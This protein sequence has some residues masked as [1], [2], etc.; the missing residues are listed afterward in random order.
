MRYSDNQLANDTV[1][2]FFADVAEGFHSTAVVPALILYSQG[3]L[4][5]EFGPL[6]P[7]HV[8]CRHHSVVFDD[9]CP[10]CAVVS[11]HIWAFLEVSRNYDGQ[12]SAGSNISWLESAVISTR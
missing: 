11:F 3:N 10:W 8:K 12:D 4:V 6:A 9:S 7:H 2:K 5:R 1:V